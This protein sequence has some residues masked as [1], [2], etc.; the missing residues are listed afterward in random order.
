MNLGTYLRLMLN[1]YHY[2]FQ[3]KIIFTGSTFFFTL[4]FLDSEWSEETIDFIFMFIFF[5][6][7]INFRPEGVDY[8][9]FGVCILTIVNWLPILLYIEYSWYFWGS[10]FDF[11]ST[12]SKL[13]NLIKKN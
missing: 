2:I 5:P 4:D 7:L 8:R 6:P 1:N 12:Y 13:R 9:S 11:P 10:F 3:F